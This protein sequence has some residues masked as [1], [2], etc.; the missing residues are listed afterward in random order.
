MSEAFNP[1]GS[2][3][4]LFVTGSAY[5]VNVPQTLD[6]GTP[7]KS[8][9]IPVGQAFS[10]NRTPEYNTKINP[11]PN[12]SIGCAGLL[13]R[14]QLVGSGTEDV[15]FEIFPRDAFDADTEQPAQQFA[16]TFETVDPVLG[17]VYAKG[18]TTPYNQAFN[19]TVEEVGPACNLLFTRAAGTGNMTV[20]AWIRRYRYYG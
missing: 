11:V 16:A 10:P 13:I 2:W 9:I 15:T 18:A 12:L 19:A 17:A 1:I 20:S 8:Q 6:A 14:I 5:T 4:P 3:I 7:V